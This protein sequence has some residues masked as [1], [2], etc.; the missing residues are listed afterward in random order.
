LD[1]SATADK[2]YKDI[3]WYSMKINNDDGTLKTGLFTERF[4]RPPMLKPPFDGIKIDELD[5]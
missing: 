2:K 4:I 3:A 1:D 5:T